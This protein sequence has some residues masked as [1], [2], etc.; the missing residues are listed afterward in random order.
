MALPY[1][2]SKVKLEAIDTKMVRLLVACSRGLVKRGL[3]HEYAQSIIGATLKR[4]DGS[5]LVVLGFVVCS[6]GIVGQG[7]DRN[8][9]KGRWRGQ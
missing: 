5:G 6:R 2:L 3:Q 7:N 9:E 1:S 4:R 8:M